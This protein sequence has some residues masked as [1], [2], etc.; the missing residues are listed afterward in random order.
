MEKY[1]LTA[2]VSKHVVCR[3]AGGFARKGQIAKGFSL[4]VCISARAPSVADGIDP[5]LTD[6][7]FSLKNSRA[8][9]MRIMQMIQHNVGEFN[10]KQALAF[11]HHCWPD[12]YGAA[13]GCF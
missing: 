4:T 6:F 1:Q 8:Y 3:I 13:S 10:E 9:F 7:L 11:S 12:G 5:F 2:V